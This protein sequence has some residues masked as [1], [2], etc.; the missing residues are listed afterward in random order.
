MAKALTSAVIVG[1]FRNQTDSLFVVYL[2]DAAQILGRN[3]WLPSQP[4]KL[5]ELLSAS[6]D[7]AEDVRITLMIHGIV[8]RTG[9][10]LTPGPGLRGLLS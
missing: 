10:R 3:G 4:K 9:D 5:A 2:L 7:D 6:M 1:W 8:V